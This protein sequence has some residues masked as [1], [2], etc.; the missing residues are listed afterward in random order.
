MSFAMILLEAVVLSSSLSLDAFIASFAYGSNKIKMS[1]PS[2]IVINLVCSGILGLSLLLGATIQPYL[3]PDVNRLLCF[4]ILF[5]IGLTKLL[6]DLAKAFIRK[7][8]RLSK[9]IRFSFLNFKFVLNVYANPEK[10]DVDH[11]KSI[12]LGEA[13]SLAVALSLDG[14]AVGFGAALGDVS[15]MAL[16]FASF[17]TDTAAI[18]LGIYLGNRIAST[19][20]FNISWLS[21]AILIVMAFLK[22]R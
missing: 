4:L 1:L 3:S 8:G 16:F 13:V 2:L 9:R 5:I 12:S 18:L 22:W 17:F 20:R 15:G 6:D 14:M 10:A 7:H 11:S 19:L 21:G